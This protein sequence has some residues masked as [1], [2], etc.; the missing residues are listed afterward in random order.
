MSSMTNPDTLIDQPARVQTLRRAVEF[1]AD[2]LDP[3][4]DTYQPYV[5]GLSNLPRDGRFLLVGNHTRV[6]LEGVLIPYVVRREIGIRVR[7]LTDRMFASMPW[8][9]PDLLA[10]CGAAV[11][12]PDNVG[13]LMCNNEPVAVFPGGRREITKFAGEEYRLLWGDRAGFAALAVANDYPIVPVASVGGDDVYRSVTT[14]DGRWGRLTE[15]VTRLVTGKSGMGLPLWRGVGTTLIPSP[16]R[17]Y[18][19]FGH[20]ITAS[21]AAGITAEERVADVREQTRLSL[22]A[23]LAGLLTVRNSDPYRDLNPLHHAAAV[24]PE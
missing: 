3:I 8:P 24:R 7:P 9:V 17:I 19:Q 18:L 16:Q 20:P 21:E 6:G 22:E 5:D 12:A 23:G 11:G 4:L 13:A 1:L 15:G 14:R 2:N 10:A